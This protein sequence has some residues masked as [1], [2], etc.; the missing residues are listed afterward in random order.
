MIL[1]I[2]D[3]Q[4][5]LML[6]KHTIREINDEY[7]LIEAENGHVAMEYLNASLVTGELPCLI[8]LDMNMPILNGKEFLEIITKDKIFADI[9]TVVFTTSTVNDEAEFCK[10]YNVEI[11]TKPFKMKV[12]FEI[13]KKI[14]LH[15]HP[16]E[17]GA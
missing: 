14:L 17:T 8:V 7:V 10:K 13:V 16:P 5:D 4:D 1:L 15:C 3:D 6:I 12:L 11:L 9:H 2:D